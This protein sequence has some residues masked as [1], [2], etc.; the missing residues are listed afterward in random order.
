MGLCDDLFTYCISG[1]D[2]AI[3]ASDEL[4]E[5]DPQLGETHTHTIHHI[6]HD[7]DDDDCCLIIK[8]L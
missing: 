1:G 8:C 2:P 5:D 6:P 4:P 7:D 3:I